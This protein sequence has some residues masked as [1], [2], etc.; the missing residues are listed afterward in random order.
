MKPQY[1]QCLGTKVNIRNPCI[2]WIS[3]F[4]AWLTIWCYWTVL[5]SLNSSDSILISY[6]APQPPEMSVTLIAIARG[7]F[8]LRICVTLSSPSVCEANMR[9]AQWRRGS[10][11]VPRS[12]GTAAAGLHAAMPGQR[13]PKIF[14]KKPKYIQLF[15]YLFIFTKIVFCFIFYLFIYF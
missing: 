9:W 12:R 14:L 8:S 4:S 6:I 5:F 13:G 15:I 10:W 2:P 1:G 7:N 3:S 11:W